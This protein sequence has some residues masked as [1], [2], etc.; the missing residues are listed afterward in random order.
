MYACDFREGL[1]ARSTP[2]ADMAACAD[3]CFAGSQ[4][5]DTK[6]HGTT[7]ALRSLPWTS[8]CRGRSIHALVC[9]IQVFVLPS[10]VASAQRRT[11]SVSE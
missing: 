10:T 3:L 9:G 2:I 7:P 4:A 6:F 11:G 8:L 5:L 1:A